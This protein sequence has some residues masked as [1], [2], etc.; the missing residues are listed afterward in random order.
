MIILAFIIF[1]VQWSPYS[2]GCNNTC[3]NLHFPIPNGV[4]KYMGHV[5]LGCLIS[6]PTFWKPSALILSTIISFFGG[7]PTRIGVYFAS[8]RCSFKYHVNMYLLIYGSKGKHLVIS[9]SYHTCILF[10]F[11]SFPYNITY[12]SRLAT[13]YGCPFITVSMWSYHWQSTYS[14]ASMPLWKWTYNNP[15]YIQDTIVVITLES[16]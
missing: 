5:T 2:F 8:N 6:G 13:S 4:A 15:W 16:G 9:S 11:N 10:I 3:W 7:S 1:L 14:F 12:M